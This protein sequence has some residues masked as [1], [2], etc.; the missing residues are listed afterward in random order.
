MGIARRI[1]ARGVFPRVATTEPARAEAD[2]VWVQTSVGGNYKSFLEA[3][4]WAK[5]ELQRTI[6]A[7]Y[8]KVVGTRAEAKAQ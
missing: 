7:G 5:D 6:D 8:A 1:E 3:G 4:D 2:A